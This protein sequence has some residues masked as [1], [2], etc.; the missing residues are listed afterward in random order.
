MRTLKLILLGIFVLYFQLIIAPKFT[1]YRIIPNF[2][3]A[4]LIFIN[5]KLE[6]KFTLPISFFLGIAFDL[7]HPSL[8]GLNTFSFL[9]ISFLVSKYHRNIN[10][11]NFA[12]VALSVCT[13]NI[14]HYLIFVIYNLLATEILPRFFLLTLFAIVYNTL[15][16]ILTIYIFSVIYKLKLSIHV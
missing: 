2:F 6:L 9:I 8:L 11:Q 16:S 13:L 3:I 10:K 4:Y 12:V 14:I 15:F 1:L 7:T 5:I